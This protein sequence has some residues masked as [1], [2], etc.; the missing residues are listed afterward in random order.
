MASDKNRVRNS[1]LASFALTTSSLICLL[2]IVALT[3]LSKAP[4]PSSKQPAMSLFIVIDCLGAVAA[5]LP[6]RCSR[7]FHHRHTRPYSSAEKDERN[8]KGK[9]AI[10]KGHHPTCRGFSTHVINVG[11]RTYC[12][13]CSGL[14]IGALTAIA[15]SI[16]YSTAVFRFEAEAIS[17]FCFGSVMVLVGLLQYMKP[18]MMK[19]SIHF[20]LNMSFV[21]GAFFL[22]VGVIEISGDLSIE[23]YLLAITLYWILIRI[24]MSDREHERICAECEQRSCTYS[25]Q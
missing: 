3:L 7:V 23:M 10:L 16:A 22:L 20:A 21:I 5:V 14:L 1:R 6:S 9:P 8:P 17:M 25:L 12:A 19:G 18:F 11:D 2:L 15:A 4:I 13:G 24:L